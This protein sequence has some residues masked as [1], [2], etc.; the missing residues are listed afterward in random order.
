MRILIISDL[1]LC[2]IRNGI[3]FEKKRLE[4]LADLILST[5]VTMVLNL[6]DVISRKEYLRPEIQSLEDGFW[7]YRAWRDRLGI[8]FV[9]CAVEREFSFFTE[10]LG[11]EPDFI[12][13]ALPNMRVVAMAPKEASDHR[14]TEEQIDFLENALRESD[15]DR[16]LIGTHVPYPGSCSRVAKAGIYLEIPERL[17]VLMEE[18]ERQIYWC[19][20]HFHWHLDPPRQLGSLTAF[21]GGRFCFENQPEKAGWLRSIDAETGKIET[22]LASFSW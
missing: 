21:Y 13:D 16:I 5:G 12:C 4:K 17:R 11:Q 15:F 19:G 1:H 8:P 2:D 18:S 22:V 6:G 14:F 10:I 20:G 7:Y 3:V 9:E